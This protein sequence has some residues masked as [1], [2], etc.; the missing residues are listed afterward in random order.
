VFLCNI[1]C[2]PSTE[3]ELLALPK[4]VFDTCEELS[5]AGWAVD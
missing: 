3:E 5:G 1:F 4:G 2:L